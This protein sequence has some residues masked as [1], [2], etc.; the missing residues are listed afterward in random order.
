MAKKLDEFPGGPPYRWDLWLDGSP[1]LLRKGED[2]EIGTPSMRAAV[3]RAAKAREKKVRTRVVR[4]K[5]GTE[6]LV[7]Q[8]YVTRSS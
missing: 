8:A 1:W 6:A 2:Y 7:V 3:S 4:E 5:D